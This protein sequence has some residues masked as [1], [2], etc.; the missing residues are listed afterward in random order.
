M[1]FLQP[2]PPKDR[3]VEQ[4]MR[5][6]PLIPRNRLSNCDAIHTSLEQA[7]Q[8]SAVYRPLSLSQRSTPASV[9]HDGP[10][11]H[12]AWLTEEDS[13]RQPRHVMVLTA[14]GQNRWMAR[15]RFK[16]PLRCTSG[17]LNQIPI[18]P[19]L[20]YNLGTIMSNNTTA[21]PN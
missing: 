10:R 4:N 14:T 6:T 12:P 11:L 3:K 17:R 1:L 16:Q 7:V 8:H 20:G 9:G 21:A 18:H 19:T 15:Y 13:I 2:P 5:N